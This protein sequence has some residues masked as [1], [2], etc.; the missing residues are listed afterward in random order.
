[1]STNL[2]GIESTNGVEESTLY[3]TVFA[4][5]S[6]LVTSGRETTR[7]CVQITVQRGSDSIAGYAHLTDSAIHLLIEQLQSV[8]DGSYSKFED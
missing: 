1:M 2:K 4:G 3:V 6:N 8:L 5:H 7:R